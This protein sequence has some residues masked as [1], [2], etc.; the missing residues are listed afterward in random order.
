MSEGVLV[1]L[2]EGLCTVTPNRPERLNAFTATM[3]DRFNATLGDAA[4]DERVRALLITVAGRGFVRGRICTTATSHRAM[5][6]RTWGSRSSY[7][8]TLRFSLSARCR[9]R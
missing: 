1:T 7:A 4:A 3:V 6:L 8:I 9:N 2:D 5:R